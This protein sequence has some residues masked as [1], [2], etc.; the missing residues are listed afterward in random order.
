[1]LKERITCGYAF[2]WIKM[3]QWRSGVFTNLMN[4]LGHLEDKHLLHFG[5]CRFQTFLLQGNIQS[6]SLNTFNFV[7]P[8]LP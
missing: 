2:K 5:E 3:D 8:I 4:D 6:F 7:L 1:M